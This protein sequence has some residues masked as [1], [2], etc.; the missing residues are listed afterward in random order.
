MTSG[1]P[2]GLGAS[3][4]VA[5]ETT[6]G[7]I[8]PPNHFY[9]FLNEKINLSIARVESTALRAGTRLQRSDHW[10]PGSIAAAGA[11]AM[12]MGTKGFG[13]LLKHA[14]GGP[15]VTTQPAVGT[16][17][18]VYNHTISPGDY[19]VGFTAQVGRPNVA[20][21]VEPFTYSGCR[22]T[23]WSLG[24]QVGQLVSFGM[25]LA[26]QQEATATALAAVTYP[27]GQPLVYTG[28]TVQ[29]GGVA[30]DAKDF[31]L[32]AKNALA[33]NRY[34]LGRQTMSQ[35]LENAYRQITGKIDAEF[36]DFVAYQRFVS[37]AE[38]V[39]ILNFVGPI[40]STTKPFSL[41]LTMNCRFDGNTP[42]VAGAEIVQQE[43][44]F[45]V[46]GN[47]SAT[48]LTAVY[49]TTDVTP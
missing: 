11:V 42:N 13:L 30:F 36:I 40:I 18:L 24:A 5:D 19:P 48:A 43:L 7:T 17:P 23:D 34:F 45:K 3:F 37:G 4:G 33:V 26:A 44:D 46:V 15:A 28:A 38:A 12:E 1:I 49:Q 2:S 20:G 8:V 35:P 32:T 25:T 47:A 41:T 31:T 22:V 27:T 6:Y 29:I 9:E 10:A 21:L 16:D 14:I 39:I